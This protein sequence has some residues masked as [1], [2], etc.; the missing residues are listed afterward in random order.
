MMSKNNFNIPKQKYGKALQ[1]LLEGNE[2]YS[3]IAQQEG[4]AS[5]G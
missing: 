1:L 4:V 2:S 3:S 5:N